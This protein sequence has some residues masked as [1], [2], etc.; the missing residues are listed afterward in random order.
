MLVSLLVMALQAATLATPAK[1]LPPPLTE[2]YFVDKGACPG[3]G[4]WLSG[5]MQWTRPAPVYDRPSPKARKIGALRANEWAEAVDREFHIAPS[6]G[7]VREP[8]SQADQ[9][10]KGDVV[11]IIGYEGE[12]WMTL[13]R[14]G[15]RLGWAAP[16][17]E[18][19]L[20]DIA[21]DPAPKTR[22]EPVM[23]V[24]IKR[25]K[26]VSGWVRDFEGLRCGGQMGR[27]DDCPPL[28]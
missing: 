24:R 23:W 21:W 9:L 12:G 8:N 26:G 2:G 3:E 22:R 4:C 17:I 5:R 16:D 1:D 28:P 18:P 20:A 13:W 6:R 15:D 7:V 25:A 10:A 19:N 11:Y 27:D 14:A